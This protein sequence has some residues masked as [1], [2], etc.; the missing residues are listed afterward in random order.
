[1][2]NV[3]HECEKTSVLATKLVIMCNVQQVCRFWLLSLKPRGANRLMC[4]YGILPTAKGLIM[5]APYYSMIGQEMGSD[6]TAFA[7]RNAISNFLLRLTSKLTALSVPY[8]TT[9]TQ[10]TAVTVCHR[11]ASRYFSWPTGD[12]HRSHFKFHTAVLSV[13]RVM[14]EVQLS[15][16]VNLSN[17]FLVQ[18]PCFSLS[19]LLLFKWLQ[20]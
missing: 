11:L 5:N 2:F 20:L 4:N 19:F 7:S 3:Q 6:H 15:A 14:F 13:L 9:R 12:P 18:L 8:T 17:T 16:V 1:M 10:T